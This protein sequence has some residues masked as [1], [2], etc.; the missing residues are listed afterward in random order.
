MTQHNSGKVKSIESL[1]DRTLSDKTT[2]ALRE[3]IVN[4]TINSTRL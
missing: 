2:T 3:A 4:G 1:Q